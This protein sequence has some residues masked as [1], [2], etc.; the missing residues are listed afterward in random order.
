MK[1]L[2]RIGLP[3][4]IA[5]VAIV[6]WVHQVPVHIT[7]DDRAAIEAVVGL[8]L[9]R[10]DLNDASFEDQV[11]FIRS[12]QKRLQREILLDDEIPFGRERE[13]VDLVERGS[14]LCFD[15]SRFL[16]KT[17]RMAGLRTRHVAVYP[18]AKERGWRYMLQGGIPSHAT[19][20]VRTKRGWMIVDSNVP[21]VARAANGSPVS[22]PDIHDGID[23]LEPPVS[24]YEYY[25][26]EGSTFIY[27]LY[28]R[29]G[30]FYPPYNPLPDVNYRE[31]LHNF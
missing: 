10:S 26:N 6:L 31:L 3:L 18:T 29:H 5:L 21:W 27:G 12:V 11:A 15:R 20:E 8:D 17:F 16:E 14:G 13:P 9:M 2:L 1:R 30:M 23:W 24:G 4:G 19:L 25:Y 28:S 7:A 22:F